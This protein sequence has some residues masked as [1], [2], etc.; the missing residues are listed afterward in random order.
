MGSFATS[1][2][3]GDVVDAA[4][5]N[6]IAGA[7]DSYTTTVSNVTASGSTVTAYKKK[8]GRCV[9]FRIAYTFA[10]T[11]TALS[12][13]GFTLPEEAATDGW[14]SFWGQAVD[15]SATKVYPLLLSLEDAETTVRM[16]AM[17]ANTTYVEGIAPTLTIPF[18]WTTSDVIRIGG[19]YEAAA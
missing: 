11:P 4:D 1:W 16:R 10:N 18:T 5:L 7:W 9:F 15:A 3:A 17:T 19:V 14:C 8:V 13:V 2:A 6:T 12:L